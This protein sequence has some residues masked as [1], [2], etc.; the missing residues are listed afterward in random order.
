MSRE[1]VEELNRH[2]NIYFTGNDSVILRNGN[3]LVEKFSGRAYSKRFDMERYIELLKS[4]EIEAY[5]KENESFIDNPFYK[6]LFYDDNPISNI[7]HN[8]LRAV[9][10]S[11][12]EDIETLHLTKIINL[13]VGDLTL[14]KVNRFRLALA[15]M[16]FSPTYDHGD[17]D[18]LDDAVI[19]D[20][21]EE[22][23]KIWWHMYDLCIQQM[24]DDN[25]FMSLQSI[26]SWLDDTFKMTPLPLWELYHDNDNIKQ[27][28]G[29]FLDIIY[30][31]QN[32]IE[33]FNIDSRDLIMDF[34]NKLI[35]SNNMENFDELLTF[36]SNLKKFDVSRDKID[37]L[38]KGLQNLKKQI[39][40]K[41]LEESIKEFRRTAIIDTTSN[42][43]EFVFSIDVPDKEPS[44]EFHNLFNLILD[45]INEFIITVKD[46]TPN[47]Q[48]KIILPDENSKVGCMRN[49]AVFVSSGDYISFSD[50]RNVNIDLF[51]LSDYIKR[52]LDYNIN[53]MMMHYHVLAA[54]LEDGEE[55]DD[56]LL[57]NSLCGIII[58]RNF[59]RKMGLLLSPFFS[60]SNDSNFISVIGV[61]YKYTTPKQINIANSLH[62]Y[63][64]YS[65]EFT[66]FDSQDDIEQHI[67]YN[68]FNL[69]IPLDVVD[70]PL[71]FFALHN[72]LITDEVNEDADEDADEDVGDGG[73][74][75]Y[76][77]NKDNIYNDARLAL[78][79]QPVIPL[80][81]Y[82]AIDV[83]RCFT[84]I[85][86][87]DD[88]KKCIKFYGR[89]TNRPGRKSK[90]YMTK[91][92]NL[93]VQY[94][95]DGKMVESNINDF[96]ETAN[97]DIRKLYGS[98]FTIKI[99]VKIVSMIIAII[100]AIVIITIV[101]NAIGEVYTSI[102]YSDNYIVNKN[103]E[104]INE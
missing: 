79:N 64:Y 12:V 42:F 62:R 60:I 33:E 53:C 78:K 41:K 35:T 23:A 22:C 45:S 40:F 58:N 86:I 68:M 27:L 38:V 15:S 81:G 8:V 74:F 87:S 76:F 5:L 36:I 66:D 93:K 29:D 73:L 55:K 3:N 51:S 11:K 48:F 89:T 61:L 103:N 56:Y 104:Y 71:H 31:Y 98:N 88:D 67:L 94:E 101:V 21:K 54:W 50:D 99:S 4:P 102:S 95:E 49:I 30:Y 1:F 100:I 7:V 69:G 34:P 84:M 52:D 72:L 19:T 20:L 75:N 59:F 9:K 83:V 96:N 85:R 17:Y 47:A 10:E 28:M 2:V 32:V 63:V 57:T 97:S 24:E 77:M 16:L 90:L 13:D 70:D 6:S 14:E 18:D 46:C 43:D 44:P 80:E 92:G 26:L 37:H 65:F 91:H 25:K 82:N 39:N